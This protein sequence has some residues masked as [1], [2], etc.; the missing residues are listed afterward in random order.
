MVKIFGLLID[1]QSIQNASHLLQQVMTLPQRTASLSFA[2][3]VQ[4]RNEK[5]PFMRH[6]FQ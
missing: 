3:D 5:T 6:F 2:D 4:N 1:K